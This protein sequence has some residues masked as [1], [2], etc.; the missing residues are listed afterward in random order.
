M[1]DFA[2]IPSF[3]S[4]DVSARRASS[5]PVTSTLRPYQYV[6]RFLPPLQVRGKSQPQKRLRSWHS[7]NGLVFL[8]I[9]LNRYF[10]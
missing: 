1:E 2:D 8:S 7:Q 5:L 4:S 10:K 3:T 6:N 9:D